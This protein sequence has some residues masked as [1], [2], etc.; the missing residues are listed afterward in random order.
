MA[1]FSSLRSASIV[2]STSLIGESAIMQEIRYLIK[3]VAPTAASVLITGPSG[4]GKEMVA[5]SIHVS[6]TRKEGNFIPV[7]CGA[8]PRDL[9]ESELF[10]HE[11]GA[12][13]GAVGQMR[14]RFEEADG[15]TLFL[16]EIGDMPFD[17]QVKLLRVL[18]DSIITRVGG[19]NPI[20][21][22]TRII[23]ATHRDIHTAIQNNGF[24]EDLFYRL[25]VFPIHLPS[26]AE[27]AEDVPL[28]ADYF[29]DR[30]PEKHQFHFTLDA[31]DYLI[32]YTWPGNI[33]ELR[34]LIERTSILYAGQ[35]VDVEQ[36]QK[37]L[38]LAI[39]SQPIERETLWDLS[40]PPSS[41][42]QTSDDSEVSLSPTESKLKSTSSQ[43]NN[44]IIF[45]DFP[46][47]GEPTKLKD[48]VS[49]LECRYIEAAL[50]AANNTV[51]DAA[52]LLGLH[53]TTLIEKMN[54]Y[55]ISRS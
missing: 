3:Q 18:E 25:A 46:S 49:E 8:I 37:L 35:T 26:L 39:V 21:V 9:L 53:R 2:A 43:F 44:E 27:R 36:T 13:T 42:A 28:L 19:R 34:N 38:N 6:S 5:S 48:L 51:S 31:L 45:S 22:D 40:S 33:R 30:L 15:G 1:P 12:F 24:R 10:G 50:K 20:R 16:D 32:Q 23:S 54:K 11:K 47:P 52:R 41:L 4:S 14:G 29:C 17:M 7:N 55:K